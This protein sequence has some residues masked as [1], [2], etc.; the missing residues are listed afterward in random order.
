VIRTANERTAGDEFKT[1]VAGNRPI[2]I[3]CFGTD[4]FQNGK[5]IGSRAEI[6]SER[7][8]G[9][10]RL[11]EVVHG[12]EEF[13]FLFAQAEHDAA[14]GFDVGAEFAGALEEVERE[15][16]L[17]AGADERGEALD[18]FQ[19]VVE[20]IGAGIEDPLEG[21][22]LA[23]K[24]GD[25]DFDD[26]FWIESTNGFDG[27][28]KVVRTAIRHIIAGYGGDDDMLESESLNALSH[29]LRFI[30]LKRKG[31]G[32][33][34]GAKA[35][36]TGAAVPRDHKSGCATAPAFPAIWALSAFADGVEA[37]VGNQILRGEKNRI[38][39]QSNFDPIGLFFEMKRR[40]DFNRAHFFKVLGNKI[41]PLSRLGPIFVTAR[42]PFSKPVQQDRTRVILYFLFP[43]SMFKS[44]RARWR[45]SVFY[46][47]I[48]IPF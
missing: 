34:D 8:D 5:M 20:H 22:V 4:V 11:A 3:K 21:I 27:F 14:F 37:Q 12:L 13:I 31:L 29:A 10:T 30:L 28:P 48:A 23:I 39:R 19:V 25:E 36:S 17:R 35:A 9:H 1:L 42:R 7:Q 38:R 43:L 40:V 24:I 45:I 15:L 16:I 33:I 44:V 41:I 2:K 47:S 18:G 26:D 6:L 32:C 46:E